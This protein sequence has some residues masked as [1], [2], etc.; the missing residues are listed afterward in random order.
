MNKR[1]LIVVI[2][3]AS[4][5]MLLFTFLIHQGNLVLL[6]P[7]GVIA[8]K[9][10]IVI[11]LFLLLSGC[12]A[13]LVFSLTFFIAWN[14]REGNKKATYAPNL[15][16]SIFFEMLWWILPLMIVVILSSITWIS[17]HELDPY[18]PI[19]KEASPITI[20]VIA[21]RWK[22][23]FIYPNQNIAS[24]NFVQIPVNTPINFELTADNAPM[25]S[26][27]IPSL[28]GQMYAMAGM[29]TKLHILAY[30]P[31]DFTGSAVEINGQGF[32]GM[33]FDVRA[34]SENKYNAWI[35]SVK[36]SSP[37]L[38]LSEY[39]RLSQPSES[40]PIKTYASIENSLYNR[41]LMKFMAPTD[42]NMPM[43]GM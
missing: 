31:G 19:E 21:L 28:A 40:E 9:E 16:H 22:W 30:T 4:Y 18:K 29:S 37:P 32:S 23:L 10:S 42:T 20:Q 13:L 1:P 34:S 27:W 2:T 25:N 17:A 38:S 43:Q 33:K 15:T 26:L 35:Q 8:A 11:A 6:N 14:Y 24:L 39:S 12:I 41:I 7:K 36:T 5:V 3:V